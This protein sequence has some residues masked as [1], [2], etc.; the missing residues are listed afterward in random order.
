MLIH[1]RKQ[2][3]PMLLRYAVCLSYWLHATVLSFLFLCMSKRL[4]W[5]SIVLFLVGL[6]DLL[7]RDQPCQHLACSSLFDIYLLRNAS[8]TKGFPL[9][10]ISVI[11]GAFGWL[12]IAWQ[13][14][15]WRSLTL[16]LATVLGLGA[17][18]PPGFHEHRASVYMFIRMVAGN[19]LEV[20]YMLGILLLLSNRP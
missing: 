9:S 12:W 4:L 8:T 6:Y 7:I 20:T 11:L 17:L 5:L 13:E 3:A 19:A 18:P 1:D 14:K 10:L 16:L 15:A 2:P